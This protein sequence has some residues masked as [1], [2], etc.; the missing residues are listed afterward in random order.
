MP[1]DEYDQEQSFRAA[2]NA[3]T[4]ERLVHSSLFTFGESVL[5]YFLVLD[6]AKQGDPVS[7][8]KGE[9]KVDRPTIITPDTSRPEFRNFFENQ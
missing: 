9:V 2:W 6:A 5:P 1:F 4:I 3:V 8:T 7:I